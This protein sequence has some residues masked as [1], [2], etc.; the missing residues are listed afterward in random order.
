MKKLLTPAGLFYTALALLA[1]I[2]AR[3]LRPILL[4]R[5]GNLRNHTLG[6]YSLHAEC[7]VADR[8]L[9][10]LQPKATDFFFHTEP[11][12]NRV[13][14]G[15]IEQRINVTPFAEYCA[16]VNA[17]IPGG[18]AHVCQL[19]NSQFDRLRDHH[20][21]YWHTRQHFSLS[22]DQITEARR[23]LREK[24]GMPENAKFICF[25]S[26]TSSY[27]Q[28]LHWHGE[29][30]KADE[31]PVENIR[32][33]NITTYLPAAERMAAQGYWLFRMG[34]V[35]DERIPRSHPNIIDYAAE[36]RS[37]LLDIYLMSHCH[38]AFSD[39]TG[40]IDLSFMFRRPVARANVVNL[41]TV[42]P[43]GEVFIPKLFW[44][45]AEQRHMTLREILS[46]GLGTFGSGEWPDIAARHGLVA[47]NNTAEEIEDLVVET[48]D[49][50]EGRWQQTATDDLLQ[51]RLK[52]IY[53]GQA[54]P[55]AGPLHAIIATSFL[56]RH[57]EF[58][59]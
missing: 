20:R 24:T 25:F 14:D 9:G 4:I 45:K 40:L 41:L 34:A 21:V 29:I 15:L 6:T 35:V 48:L 17:N 26:R 47:H 11:R 7:Y 46:L 28:S 22:D 36:F 58:L 50:L 43:W 37:E 1:V 53:A 16:R 19:G 2:A 12:A 59:D 27:L 44:R 39:T 51:A 55:I 23:I 13:L 33:S 3:L 38:M 8:E 49:R 31:V 42:Y 32:D 5:F 52:K 57:P 54:L 56:R 30:R 10:I 18:A